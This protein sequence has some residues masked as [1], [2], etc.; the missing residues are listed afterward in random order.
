[1]YLCD[2]VNTFRSL[3]EIHQMRRSR[4]PTRHHDASRS[5]IDRRSRDVDS[6]YLSD[7]ER[8]VNHVTVKSCNNKHLCHLY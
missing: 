5:P 3:D 4:S 7:Q 2:S 6:L 1:M 8:Y